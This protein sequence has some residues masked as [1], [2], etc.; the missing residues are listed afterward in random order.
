MQPCCTCWQSYLMT[1]SNS[2]RKFPHFLVYFLLNTMLNPLVHFYPPVCL[3]LIICIYIFTVIYQTLC[4]SHVPYVEC[5]KSGLAAKLF[6]FLEIYF[7]WYG[8]ILRDITLCDIL[9]IKKGK[10]I[11]KIFS[12]KSK[13]K[14]MYIYISVLW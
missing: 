4:L 3:M 8:D 12:N 10:F 13:I 9:R 1:G 14:Y 2:S 11:I 5:M 6:I 7:F